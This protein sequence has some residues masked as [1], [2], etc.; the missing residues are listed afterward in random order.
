MEDSDELL[1]RRGRGRDGEECC[2]AHAL[3]GMV[4]G[5]NCFHGMH[6]LYVIMCSTYW[7]TVRQSW[8]KIDNM[9]VDVK[10]FRIFRVIRYQ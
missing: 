9:T 8:A 4:M 7:V 3:V 2:D 1:E 5:Q 6:G 10:L